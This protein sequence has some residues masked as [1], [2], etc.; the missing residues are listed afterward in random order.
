[1]D[2]GRATTDLSYFARHAVPEYVC[3]DVPPFHQAIFKAFANPAEKR[4]AV[5]APRGFAKST[6]SQVAI[7]HQ[8]AFCPKGERRYILVVSES[9]SQS[10][11]YLDNIKNI[12]EDGDEFKRLFPFVKPG[13]RWGADT[14]LTSTGVKVEVL[15][16]RQRVRGRNFRGMRPSVVFL[17]D[18]ESETNSGSAEDRLR[19]RKWI[20]AAVVPAMSR[21]KGRL[22][23]CGTIIHEDSYLNRLM[24]KKVK[25][26]TKFFFRA[27]RMDG[28]PH[29]DCYGKDGMLWGTPRLDQDRISV[30]FDDPWWSAL[31]DE[32]GSEGQLDAFYQEYQNQVR[33]GN[34]VFDT[35]N[36]YDAYRSGPSGAEIRR[37]GEDSWTPVATFLGVDPSTREHSKADFCVLMPIGVDSNKNIYQL[38]YVRKR[39]GRDVKQI[40]D[41][42]FKLHE[43][44]RFRAVGIEVIGSQVYISGEVKR[45]QKERNRWFRVV[46][47]NPNRGKDSKIYSL[48]PRFESGLL[49][50]HPNHSDELQYE[51]QNYPRARH[52]D[53]P[54]ALWMACEVGYPISGL[55]Q[56]LRERASLSAFSWKV[57]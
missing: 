56:K 36:Y 26:W 13:S 33:P 12:I 19:V 49:H 38:P 45:Q 47:L 54:D 35:F 34:P 21:G 15:G 22:I 43:R 30:S 6:L 27:K 28:D 31:R 42:V 1:M 41:E 44:F 16:T 17:D 37:L 40:V 46:E 3:D 39:F 14:I 18:F 52:D 55:R 53:C 24:D 5:V 11:D 48:Q 9:Q 10:S 32:F 8:I 29:P 57:A 25:G 50:L 51:L 2:M 20:R 4:I 23:A 7:L